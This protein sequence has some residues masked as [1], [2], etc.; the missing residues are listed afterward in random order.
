M[1]TQRNRRHRI[2]YWVTP[3]VPPGSERL[4]WV[5]SRQRWFPRTEALAIHEARQ[6]TA[7]P[8]IYTMTLSRAKRIANL[9]P[10]GATIERMY[11]TSSVQ[12]EWTFPALSEQ[13]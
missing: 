3:L 2:F 9:S 4:M 6:C 13:T 12:K 11:G 5:P 8:R 7:W 1:K 10:T